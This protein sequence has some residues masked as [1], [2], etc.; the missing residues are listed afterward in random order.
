VLELNP[1]FGGG[2]PFTHRA[3]ANLPAALIAWA[4]GETIDP[5]W[6]VM[7]PD[8]ATAKCDRLVEIVTS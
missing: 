4:A 3:G 6:L 7:Q 8:V 5:R 2:Y 1:R